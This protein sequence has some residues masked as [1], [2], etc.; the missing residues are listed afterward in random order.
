MRLH[1][2]SG[3]IV[4]LSWAGA[5]VSWPI[6][7]AL[8]AAAQ[9]LGVAAAGGGWIGVSLAISQT[10]WGLVNEPGVGFAATR[11]ALFLYWLAPPLAA[12]L[13][14]F[15]VPV[16]TPAPMGWVGEVVIFHIGTA[17]AVL[18][19]GWAGP[20]GVRDG[21]AAGLE[22]FWN[23][24]PWGFVA[25]CLAVGA[26]AVQFALVRLSGHLWIEPGGPTRRRRV[27]VS[28]VHSWPPA[29]LWF[30]TACAVSGRIPVRPAL[31][32]LVV[33]VAGTCGS[34]MLVAGSPP[35]P[36]R[37]PGVASLLATLVVGAAL[38][39]GLVWAAGQ[40]GRPRALLWGAPMET[41]NLRPEM[42]VERLTP[43]RGPKTPPA[44]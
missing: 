42:T 12:L 41:N 23:V 28:I 22:R 24:H 4:V 44:R 20:L 16:L 5:L 10:P 6:A 39:V 34:F 14:A 18:G 8:L 19:L 13:L 33:L 21:P 40:T 38:W 26:S 29:L 43:R 2:L 9:G 32:M 7:W 11:A 36:Y 1:P 30:A 3:R 25:V 37:E 35:R 27:T 31:A 15:C 17:A